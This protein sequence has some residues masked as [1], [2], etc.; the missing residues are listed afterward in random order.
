MKAVSIR[1][2]T[3]AVL[4]TL[5]ANPLAASA[6]TERQCEKSQIQQPIANPNT[7]QGI[8][9]LVEDFFKHNCR[10]ITSRKTI[11]WGNPVTDVNGNVSISY[12]Y[13]MIIWDKD[14]FLANEIFTFDKGGKFVKAEKV[15]G[16]PKSLGTVP[17]SP[18]DVS[19]KEAV[20]KLV[21]KF[22]TRNYLDISARK[23]LEWGEPARDANNGNV[24][25]RYK[26]EA[27]IRSK[28]KIINDEIFTFDKNGHYVSVNK[29]GV[30]SLDS[31]KGI[32]PNEFGISVYHVD[33]TV[34]S[35]PPENDFSRPEGTY[36]VANRLIAEGNDPSWPSIS[37]AQIASN[38]RESNFKKR[39]VSPEK[40]AQYLNAVILEVYTKSDFATVIARFPNG[41]GY[42]VRAF[43][44]ESGK[45]L[46]TGQSCFGSL[47]KARAKAIQLIELDFHQQPTTGTKQPVL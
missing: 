27:T 21:E 13:E 40:A 36:V 33:K 42:D 44:R 6:A 47:P 1:I 30:K 43:K 28:D 29:V 37:A 18:E 5:A 15:E 31:Y 38:M 20:Q 22:F 46:N 7:K 25:L 8:Q 16:F 45:W 2:V 32:D 10:D 4:V 12:K 39:K 14:K 41:N 11:E 26:Y 9:A 24:S 23:T 19:T 3:V 35:F 34:A 17:V